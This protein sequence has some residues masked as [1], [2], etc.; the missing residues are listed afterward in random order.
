[1]ATGSSPRA[2]RRPASSTATA[3][4]PT[5]VGPN[6]AITAGAAAGNLGFEP[7]AHPGRRRRPEVHVGERGAQVEAGAADDDRPPAGRE[8]RVD[9]GVRERHELSDRERR[10]D[11]DE[12]EQAV[13]ETDP[14]AH[15]GGAGERL[16]TGVDLERVGRDRDRPLAADAQEV[17]ERDR[18][19]GLADAGGAEERD[20]LALRRDPFGPAPRGLAARARAPAHGAFR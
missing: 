9:L 8:G 15:V 5:P 14:V 18:H 3:V 17:G 10:V 13:L 7:L 16:E 12:A 11:R 4:L 19:L 20:Y 1:M 6:I 2:R